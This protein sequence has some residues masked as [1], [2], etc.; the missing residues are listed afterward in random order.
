MHRAE[1]ELC[2]ATAFAVPLQVLDSSDPF[3]RGSDIPLLRTEAA[4]APARSASMSSRAAAGP[5]RPATGPQLRAAP[6]PMIF[7]DAPGATLACCKQMGS[8]LAETA[9]VKGQ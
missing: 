7:G 3:A 9:F 8:V 5:A 2:R 4:A 1:L 6:L